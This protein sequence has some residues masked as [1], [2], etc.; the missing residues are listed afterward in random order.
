AADQAV[1][2]KVEVPAGE[3]VRFT[4]DSAATTAGTEL[5]VRYGQ[6]PSRNAFDFAANE[7]FL[8]DQVLTM[9]AEQGGTYY[10]LAYRA[11]L[12]GSPAFTIRADLVPF[13]VSRATTGVGGDSGAFTL[14][15]EGARFNEGTTFGLVDG[16]GTAYPADRTVVQDT[17]TA[18]VTFNLT[19]GTR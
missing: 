11:S 10:V 9:P 19:L 18:Y 13:S 12:T 5:Y 4:L 16:A 8:P 15:V 17:T 2:Y 7:P 6:M 14:K 3:T 1:Y